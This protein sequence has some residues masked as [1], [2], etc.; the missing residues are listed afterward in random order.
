MDEELRQRLAECQPEPDPLPNRI[1]RF[2]IKSILYAATGDA[3]L[4]NRNKVDTKPKEYS[5]NEKS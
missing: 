1:L 2:V 4:V 3:L 5:R